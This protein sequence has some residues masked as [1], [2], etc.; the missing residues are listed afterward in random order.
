M[1]LS[2]IPLDTRLMRGGLACCNLHG[3]FFFGLG[4]GGA[5]SVCCKLVYIRDAMC[6]EY[7]NVDTLYDNFRHLKQH[8]KRF[9]RS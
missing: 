6:F 7:I 3:F 4:E 5:K 1:L 8:F 2:A 9:N